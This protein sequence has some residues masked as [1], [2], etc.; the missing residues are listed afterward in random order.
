MTDATA[1]DVTGDGRLEAV[2][3]NLDGYVYVYDAGGELTARR[4]L[5]AGVAKLAAVRTKGQRRSLVVA[6]AGPKLAAIRCR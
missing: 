5:G 4:Q 2:A 6:A 3:G 1:A